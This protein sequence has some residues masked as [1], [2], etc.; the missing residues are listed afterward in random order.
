MAASLELFIF[1]AKKGEAAAERNGN[2][3]EGGIKGNNN[4]A[5]RTHKQVGNQH[6]SKPCNTVKL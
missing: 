5:Q 3:R 2:K 6:V 1:K 4:L